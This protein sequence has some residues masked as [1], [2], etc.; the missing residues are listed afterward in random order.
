MKNFVLASLI[1]TSLTVIS[2][3]LLAQD[4]SEFVFSEETG[5]EQGEREKLAQSIKEVRKA[6]RIAAIKHIESLGEPEQA[7]LPERRPQRPRA[8][9]LE[10]QSAP[11]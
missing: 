6:Q 9:R 10:W 2:Q 11:R 7:E 4:N 5:Q 3:P 1:I 8:R